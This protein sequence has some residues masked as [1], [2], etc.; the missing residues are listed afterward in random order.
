[1]RSR[2]IGVAALLAATWM[3]P[4]PASA[5]QASSG[6]L[7]TIVATVVGVVAGGIIGSTVAAGTT[8]TVIGAALGGGIACWWYDDSLFNYE[9]LPRK[10]ALRV[11]P[12][13]KPGMVPGLQLVAIRR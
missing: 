3:T 10:A 9:P 1:M 6:E 12:S 4:V 11:P 13:D 8:A 7:G 2:I 5:Q